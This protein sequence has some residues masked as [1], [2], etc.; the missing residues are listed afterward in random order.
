MVS[1]RV[2]YSGKDVYV[3][4][5]VHKKKYV[6]VAVCEGEEVKKA[7]CPANPLTFTTSINKWFAGAKIYSCYEAGFSGFGLH[8]LLTESG[9]ENIVVNPSSIEVASN[10]RVKTDKRDAHKMASHLAAGRL[11]GIYIPT[12]QEELG[13]LVTRTREQLVESR[14]RTGIQ[15]K[16]KLFQFGFLDMD[17]DKSTSNK[18]LKEVEAMD[19]PEELRFALKQ[20]IEIWREFNEKILHCDAQMRK[21]AQQKPTLERIYRSVPG[22]GPVTARTLANEL[23]DMSRFQNAKGLYFLHRP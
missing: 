11:R 22:V 12:V 1:S 20:L 9:V 21:Q 7:S 17:R 13:R 10:D 2:V 4:I 6:M 15:I 8:R 3:G 18:F 14:S 16:A 5:D 23:D 19:L